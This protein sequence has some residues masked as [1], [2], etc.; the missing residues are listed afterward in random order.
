M[1]KAL[2]L[3]RDGVINKEIGY[4]YRIEEFKFICGVFETCRFF[5]KAGYLLVVITNQAGIARGYYS[6]E[7]F[8]R[9]T[10]WMIQQ[11][12]NQGIY[13]AKTYYSP[14]HPTQGIGKYRRD[15][16][17]RK[18]R[19]GMFF[20]AQREWEI[21]LSQS[22]I[23]GDKESDIQAGLAANIGLKVLVRSG[24]R[25]DDENATQ[26]DAIV[27]SIRYLPTLFDKVVIR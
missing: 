2:F 27:D 12:A 13:I 25:L 11:F 10:Y 18:P 14:N 20:R 1:R 9:L 5:Q 15:C 4:L 24:H 17:D 7:D 26:A 23:V 3:D 21:D 22:I 8:H 6:E 16:Q 19:P